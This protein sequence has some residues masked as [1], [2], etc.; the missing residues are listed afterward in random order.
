MVGAGGAAAGPPRRSES[1]RPWLAEPK[2]VRGKAP[3]GGPSRTSASPAS[4]AGGCAAGVAD[5]HDLPD[6][7]AVRAVEREAERQR[8]RVRLEVGIGP[9]AVVLELQQVALDG[10]DGLGPVDHLDGDL[11]IGREHPRQRPVDDAL[12]IDRRGQ[13]TP[14]LTRP[15]SGP[16]IGRP[17]APASA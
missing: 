7:L 3:A 15:R 2:P 10:H 9:V 12:R 5:G 13:H 11:A 17:T 6:A 14:Q 16:G 4:I 1:G 8:G